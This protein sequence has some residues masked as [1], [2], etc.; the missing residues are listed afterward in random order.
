MH[1]YVRTYIH[2]YIQGS[3]V[4]C[5]ISDYFK[6]HYVARY[7]PGV[8]VEAAA[9]WSTKDSHNLSHWLE[10]MSNGESIGDCL[11][12]GFNLVNKLIKEYRFSS[13]LHVFHG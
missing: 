7:Q 9:G 10:Q 12:T 11:T 1:T 2:T 3:H 8:S 5:P 6:S 13:L 4:Q